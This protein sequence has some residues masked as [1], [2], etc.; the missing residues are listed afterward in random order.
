MN[1][2]PSLTD[3]CHWQ[4]GNY[5][6]N[7]IKFGRIYLRIFL[8][9]EKVLLDDDNRT[10]VGQQL[11]NED[12]AK[13]RE[14]GWD[15]IEANYTKDFKEEHRLEAYGDKTVWYYAI[16]VEMKYSVPKMWEDLYC[17]MAVPMILKAAKRG[18]S[19]KPPK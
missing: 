17:K 7:G 16:T 12:V 8:F 19:Q 11:S 2:L 4:S 13:Y 10:I 15:L 1:N 3:N 9:P 14:M 5:K 6:R 18:L